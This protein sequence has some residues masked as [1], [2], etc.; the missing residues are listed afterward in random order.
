MRIDVETARAEGVAWW[1][2]HD[3]PESASMAYQVLN[4]AR[5]LRYLETGALGSKAEGGIWLREHDPDPE[6][7]A[8]IDT[9]L[10][11]QRGDAP[12]HRDQRVLEAFV[13]RVVAS[14]REAAAS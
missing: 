10:V 12:E 5:C 2:D 14:L 11:Y 6:V 9:A 13:D 1:A 8:L 4:G 7:R 3:L